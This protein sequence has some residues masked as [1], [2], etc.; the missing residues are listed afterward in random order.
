MNVATRTPLSRRTFLRGAGAVLA[1]P[2]LECMSS[3][4]GR[5]AS[6]AAPTPRFVGMMT[7]M[8]ILPEFFFP[9]ARGPR[10]EATPYLDILQAQRDRLTVLSGVS[11]PGVDGGHAAENCF[12]TGAPGAGRAS[13]RNSV[14][15]DQVMA[16]KVG[17]STRFPSLSLMIGNG[18]LSLSWTRSGSMIPPTASPLALYQQLFVEDT[19][20]GKAESLRRLGRDRSLLDGLREQFRDLQQRV[21]TA[22]R[23]RLEQFAA[24]VRDLEKNLAATQSWIDRPKPAV[25]EPPPAEIVDPHD[26][27][28][29][30]RAMLDLV[31]L[32]IET[33]STRIVTVCLSTNDLSP[34]NIAGVTGGT[35]PL[36]HH[37]KQP[38]K[39]AELRRIEEAHFRALSD[40]FAGLDA[41]Q[42]QGVSLLDHT[43]CLYGTNMGSANAHSNDNL[44]VLLVGGRFK[45]AGHL[46]FDRANNYPLTNLHVSLLR[47][48]GIESDTFASGTGTL[49]GL[50][51]S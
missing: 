9:A 18:N 43:A 29:N 50:E 26:F 31:R 1:L 47:H 48:L 12:L 21:S 25:D 22:D 15:L 27:P 49:R 2:W 11:L 16:E 17:A 10:Y 40:F 35:H 41:I 14:S 44:P 28:S 33:D 23:D 30:A 51:T 36:T 24:A 7:N 13:F 42:E 3:R 4:L 8:G 6:V 5:A 46:A 19:P 39:I 45:H 38:E 37:G 32:A 20:A 34:K